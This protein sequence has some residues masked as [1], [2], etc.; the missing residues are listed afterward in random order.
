MGQREALLLGHSASFPWRQL[1]A[2]PLTGHP[3]SPLPDTGVENIPVL[4]RLRRSQEATPKGP[5]YTAAQLSFKTPSS[6]WRSGRQPLLRGA[7]G[8]AAKG[9]PWAAGKSFF[10]F[11]F[12]F[13]YTFFLLHKILALASAPSIYSGIRDLSPAGGTSCRKPSLITATASG[14]PPLCL[15]GSSGFQ[16]S[17]A[18]L[19]GLFFTV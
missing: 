6:S 8:C 14:G 13:S 3:S 19:E 12:L 15:F 9:I 2:I 17:C 11:F 10:F 16:S 18:R 1:L 4:T 5:I 7:P